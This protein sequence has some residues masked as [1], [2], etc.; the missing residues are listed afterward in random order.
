V[1]HVAFS[2]KVNLSDATKE[3][4]L[5][6]LKRVNT[7][8]EKTCA[9]RMQAVYT[10][11]NKLKYLTDKARAIHAEIETIEENIKKWYN[12]DM[13]KS[14][15]DHNNQ[16]QIV[17]TRLSEKTVKAIEDQIATAGPHSKLIIEENNVETFTPLHLNAPAADN[18]PTF[19]A[20]D[21]YHIQGKG[22]L[23]C[24]KPKRRDHLK[25]GQDVI[26]DNHTYIIKAL[27]KRGNM[28]IGIL[29]DYQK[30]LKTV[31]RTILKE[32]PTE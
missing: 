11:K 3:Q 23:A 2:L 20:L 17:K 24:I 16:G 10:K 15:N 5:K 22:D 9:D 32:P 1:K 25:I 30:G 21:W 29:V 7:A 4:L 19:T 12:E 27:E 14:L 6:E 8:I 13:T 18:R 28:V 26:I 31:R